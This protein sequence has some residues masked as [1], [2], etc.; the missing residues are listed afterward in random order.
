MRPRPFPIGVQ[1]VGP[2]ILKTVLGNVADVVR[3]QPSVEGVGTTDICREVIG[4]ASA[5]DWL[6][7]L[8]EPVFVAWNR[9]SYLQH[10]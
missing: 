4:V 1:N 9:S 6:Q 2:D 3:C 8:P 7:D 5:N 10:R